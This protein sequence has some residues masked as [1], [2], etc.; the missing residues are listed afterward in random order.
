MFVSEP[1][2]SL[3]VET[4]SWPKHHLLFVK[5]ISCSC[6]GW[7]RICCIEVFECWIPV[8][9][10][11]CVGTVPHNA[12]SYPDDGTQCWIRFVCFDLDWYRGFAS[13]ELPKSSDSIGKF[14]FPLASSVFFN[15]V[16]F[17][18]VWSVTRSFFKVIFCCET[19]AVSGFSKT[20]YP[21]SSS[22]T[23]ALISSNLQIATITKEFQKTSP[24]SA[25]AA[26]SRTSL[27]SP[28]CRPVVVHRA[29]Y[30]MFRTI[31]KKI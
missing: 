23:A 24:L 25:V 6:D 12:S 3:N 7:H 18:N 13:C 22:R 30:S 27:T 15:Q 29:D 8:G 11:L 1:V 4:C 28:S 9:E 21:N 17:R 10:F 20:R 2:I 16:L 31:L 5:F 26:I 14:F 19:K